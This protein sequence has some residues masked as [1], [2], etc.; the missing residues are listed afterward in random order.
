[1]TFTATQGAALVRG[2]LINV[3]DDT[4]VQSIAPGIATVNVNAA[5]LAP[6]VST[7]G[8]PNYT[9]GKDPVT[10]ISSVTITDGDSA[11]MSGAVVK[12]STLGQSGDVLG[13][14]APQGNPITATWDAATKTLTLSGTATK[15][16]YEE[17]LKAV[18]FSATMGAGLVRG[19]QISVTDSTGLSSGFSGAATATVATPL[20]PAIGTLGAPTFTIG[21]GPVTC[22]RR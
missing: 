20:P 18:T 3:T 4:G 22:S 12:I 21:G 5:P 17:A 10:L 14:T 7:L 19:F 8:A 13:Y 2:L 15:A 6:L 11:N 1:V 9:I 16:Q